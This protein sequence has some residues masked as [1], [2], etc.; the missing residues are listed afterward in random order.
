MKIKKKS[1]PSDVETKKLKSTLSSAKPAKSNF[2]VMFSKKPKQKTKETK[3][4]KKLASPHTLEERKILELK[5]EL[6]NLNKKSEEE[7]FTD[8]EGRRYCSEENCDQLAVTGIYC[9]YHY[10]F[11]WKYLRT[12]KKLLEEKYLSRTIQE[13]IQVFGE[14]GLHCVLK[15]LKNEKTFEWATKEMNFSVEKE[16]HTLKTEWES[17]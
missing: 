9:R 7:V 10:L 12:K 6:D 2:N 8:V 14:E 1:Q 4:V 11:L 13:L 3:K 15:D 5:K 16:E 17:F